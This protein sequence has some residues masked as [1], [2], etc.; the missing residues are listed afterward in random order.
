MSFRQRGK[1][2]ETEPPNSAANPK[3][4]RARD[5]YTR[6][7]AKQTGKNPRTIQRDIRIG[8]KLKDY[9][10][11]LSETPIA[12]NQR[13]L[14]KLSNVPDDIR[15]D[16]VVQLTR[17][18]ARDVK[19]ALE[20]TGMTEKVQV[21][22]PA[23]NQDIIT[24]ATWAKLENK[25]RATILARRR[26]PKQ[27]MYVHSGDIIEFARWSWNPITA[28]RYNFPYCEARGRASDFCE[29]S[30]IPSLIPAQLGVPAAFPVPARIA[31][32]TSSRCVFV[33]STIDVF[34]KCVPK[35]WIRAVLQVVTENPQWNFLF[36][37]RSPKRLAEFTF[38]PNA[39][40]GTIVDCQARVK[41]AETAFRK[42]HATIKW[43]LCEPLL[44][45]LEFTDLSIVDWLVI[46]GRSE[47]KELPAWYPPCEWVEALVAAAEAANCKVWEKTNLFQRRLEYPNVGVTQPTLEASFKDLPS[48]R[49]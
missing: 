39:W 14:L 26:A 27:G 36:V 48:M 32:D 20:Q 12:N 6:E 23:G 21:E 11:A 37:S 4:T 46:G 22:T 38:P 8:E 7:R 10:P 24:L 16:V 44:E 41:A 40:V 42:T 29:Q 45:P 31:H 9:V 49:P 35:P 13:E 25:T 15:G 30:F 18:N 5:A 33:C 2:D 17:G 3:P 43:L 19:T 34:G 47:T 1:S 28:C